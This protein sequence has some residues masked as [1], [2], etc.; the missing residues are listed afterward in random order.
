MMKVIAW[1]RGMKTR[2]VVELEL[3]NW[4]ALRDIVDSF[5]EHA[6]ALPKQVA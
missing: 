2:G 3:T 4:E 1:E 5:R 6:A